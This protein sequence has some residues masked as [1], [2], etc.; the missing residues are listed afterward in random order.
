[1]NG[2]SW[3]SERYRVIGADMQIKRLP[4]FEDLEQLEMVGRRCPGDHSEV[5]G[6]W[7]I[8]AVDNE[9]LD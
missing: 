1:M 6:P 4:I 7:I 9:L 5:E 8:T 2:C 3:V